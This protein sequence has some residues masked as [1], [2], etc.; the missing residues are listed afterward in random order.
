[1]SWDTFSDDC[2]GCRPV[3][4]DLQTGQ[5]M[6]DD[7]EVMQKVLAFWRRTSRKERQVFHRITCQNSRVPSDLRI[8]Q[9]LGARMEKSLKAG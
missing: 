3:I 2:P 1:M 7:S 4:V 8:M 5:P 9:D 6:P